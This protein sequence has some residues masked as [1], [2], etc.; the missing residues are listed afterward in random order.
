MPSRSEARSTSLRPPTKAATGSRVGITARA[1]LPG[2]A[3]DSYERALAGFVDWLQNVRGAT[4]TLIPQVTSD[5]QG[6][7]D[8]IVARRVASHCTTTPCLVD[9]RLDHRTLCAVYADLDYLVGT[10]FHSVIFGLLSGTPALAIEYEH[11]TSGIMGDL[12]LSEWVIPIR[13][14]SDAALRMRFLDLEAAR[15]DYERQIKQRL[16]D[17]VDRAND[18]VTVLRRA[19]A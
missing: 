10:R 16:P 11:K 5:Y 19:V 14:V 8:R 17:Y 3:Q 12:G 18:F 9:G 13:E 6:D 7:D 1:W 2:P 4:V 15:P